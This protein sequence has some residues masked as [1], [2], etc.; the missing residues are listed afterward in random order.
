M[1]KLI[2]TRLEKGYV[3]G[4]LIAFRQRK[5]GDFSD[6]TPW[7]PGRY[8]CDPALL[9]LKVDEVYYAMRFDRKRK[10]WWKR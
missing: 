3:R 2:A 8:S 5:V 7:I 4:S 10:I 9:E 6:G 1:G